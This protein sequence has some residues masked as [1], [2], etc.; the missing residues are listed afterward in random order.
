MVVAVTSDGK[1]GADLQ[2][3]VDEEKDLYS[4]FLSDC[5]VTLLVYSFRDTMRL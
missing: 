2:W 5:T 3:Q 4:R 1:G